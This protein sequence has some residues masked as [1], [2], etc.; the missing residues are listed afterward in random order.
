MGN[1]EGV[2]EASTPS[3]PTIPAWKWT[4]LSTGWAGGEGICVCCCLWPCWAWFPECEVLRRFLG[5]VSL[6]GATSTSFAAACAC[7]RLLCDQPTLA[8]CDLT[9]FLFSRP[10]EPD[11]KT[12]LSPPLSL[13]DD[14]IDGKAGSTKTFLR[15]TLPSYREHQTFM[16]RLG[17]ALS[18]SSS[19][20][21]SRKRWCLR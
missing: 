21:Q 13:F 14:C 15:S 2:V 8:A 11:S 5:V 9:Y 7:F 6:F 18:L 12:K 10:E 1:V 3:P 20:L 19:V 16:Q 17:F 4:D